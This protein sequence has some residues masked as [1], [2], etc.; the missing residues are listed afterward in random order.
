[1]NTTTS[2][3]ARNRTS[4]RI[5]A[6]NDSFRNRWPIGDLLARVVVPLWVAI[7]AL[8]KLAERDPRL[9]PQPIV[10]TVSQVAVAFMEQRN[11]AWLLDSTLR[12]LIGIELALVVGMV[13][14]PRISRLLASFTLIV[15]LVVLAETMRRQ[16]LSDGFQAMIS[17]NCGCL[18]KKSPPPPIMFLIDAVLLAGV[19]IFQLRYSLGAASTRL[20]PLGL[21]FGCMAAF[22]LAFM[23]P[24]KSMRVVF[25]DYE[26]EVSTHAHDHWPA[27]PEVSPM[28]FPQAGT[29]IGQHMREI[30]LLQQMRP[31]PA[32]EL[33]EG[34]TYIVVYRGDCGNC[35]ELLSVH[36]SEERAPRT[37]ALRIAEGDPAKDKPMPSDRF[38]L[39]TL[40][41]G[42][43]YVLTAPLLAVAR[44]GVIR[45]A[46]TGVDLES[47][48]AMLSSVEDEVPDAQPTPSTEP[49]APP[50]A[51][52]EPASR[53]TGQPTTP[54]AAGSAPESPRAARAWP[55][56]PEVEG[57]YFPQFDQWI[58]RRIDQQPLAL[59]IGRPVSLNEGR[60]H[61]IFYRADC[62]V[63][64]E[65]MD[66]YLVGD[67]EHRVIAVR[68]P[69]TDPSGD[70][71]MPLTNAVR[72]SLPEGPT[73]VL[74][75]PV[76]LTVQDGVVLCMATDPMDDA[77]VIG[78]L[79]A[80]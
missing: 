6:G 9:L 18:G 12:T 44:D 50:A 79:S 38:R 36:M 56:R 20:V 57:L 68:I 71:P 43:N 17:G 1:M 28:Y 37:I 59:Q 7:G 16:V 41:D 51:G 15:F 75:T 32:A 62:D 31:A 48:L 3:A 80:E 46:S 72:R 19:M 34:I 42:P 78:C 77:S 39:H 26:E 58:G 64:H 13:L 60:W 52:R 53:P 30:D 65:M 70:L 22:T 49:V 66:I 8:I 63:C 14:A 10:D 54:P 73:Y 11:H 25:A 47:A 29:W 74:T 23:T 21:V 55:A 40:P 67:F 33:L 5:D 27:P 45:T 4:D 76:L 69:D 24:P 61:V 35:H 2:D